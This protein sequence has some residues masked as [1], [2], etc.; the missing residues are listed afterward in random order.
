[1]ADNTITPAKPL[2]DNNSIL[3]TPSTVISNSS[4]V[5]TPLKH[6]IYSENFGCIESGEIQLIL[7]P[8]FSGKTTEL[9]RR[10]RRY[11]FAHRKC[12][13][14][15]YAADIRYSERM[16]STHDQIQVPA[17]ATKLLADIDAKLMEEAEIIAVDE[18]TTIYNSVVI[19]Q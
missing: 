1:M 19:I 9:L 13:I 17:V 15:K 12:F 5:S 4:T 11:Q 2:D 6:R 16:A 7:G 14:I 8:M 18:G 10:V 3:S